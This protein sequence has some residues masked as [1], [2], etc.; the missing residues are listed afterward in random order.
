MGAA[1]PCA[2]PIRLSCCGGLGLHSMSTSSTA[3]AAATPLAGSAGKVWCV[4]CWATPWATQTSPPGAS[5]AR[6]PPLA[7]HPHST[8]Q[9]CAAVEEVDGCTFRQDAW[10]RPSGGGGITRVMQVR[11][12]PADLFV[13]EGERPWCTHPACQ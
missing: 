6:P 12:T 11:N 1:S 2:C 10:T 13:R 5:S 4:L 3:P 7:P 8:H 9:V